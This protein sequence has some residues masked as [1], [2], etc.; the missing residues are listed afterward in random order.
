[1]AA[2][3]WRQD[4]QEFNKLLRSQSI[5]RRRRMFIRQIHLPHFNIIR[6]QPVRPGTYP[7]I[8]GQVDDRTGGLRIMFRL[9]IIWK[10]MCMSGHLLTPL[11]AL[12]SILEPLF[13]DTSTPSSTLLV[14]ALYRFFG[15]NKLATILC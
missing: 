10:V 15:K 11:G 14:V 5:E 3:G 1:M 2:V 7:S 6:S 8:S 12:I 13:F 4:K 9:Q